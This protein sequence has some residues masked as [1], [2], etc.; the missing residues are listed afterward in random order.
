[1]KVGS[2]PKVE[3]PLEYAL[4]RPSV[5]HSSPAQYDR[6][7]APKSHHGS[8]PPGTL[9]YRVSGASDI[10]SN[11]GS[12]AAFVTVPNRKLNPREST[13]DTMPHL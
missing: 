8:A 2:R 10:L 1:M 7:L 3:L 11:A 9:C 13:H 12:L 5:G 6:H 4:S